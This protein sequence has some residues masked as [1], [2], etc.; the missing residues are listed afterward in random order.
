[1]ASGLVVETPQETYYF[2]HDKLRQAIYEGIETPH[3]RDL[4]LRV[5][6]ALDD[7]KVEP[8]ELAHHY[9]RAKTWRPALE[10]QLRLGHRSGKL[11]PGFG[12]RG[13]VTGVRRN[14]IRAA[15]IKGEAPGAYGPP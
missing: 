6:R 14:E 5:A 10:N 1:M 11:R 9:L 12:G 2:A 15:G 4:H 3:R 13:R 7:T 8:A